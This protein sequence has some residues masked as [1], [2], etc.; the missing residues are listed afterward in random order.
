LES[1]CEESDV[2]KIFFIFA[3]DCIQDGMHEVVTKL[4]IEL[5][6]Q[7]IDAV[8]SKSDWLHL[9]RKAIE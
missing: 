2:R 1:V 4:F 8:Y 7:C 6:S 9:Q 3:S 5:L